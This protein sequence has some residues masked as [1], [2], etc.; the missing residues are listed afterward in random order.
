MVSTAIGCRRIIL[1]GSPPLLETVL[2]EENA[3]EQ[4]KKENGKSSR[5]IML[6]LNA[7]GLFSC[8]TSKPEN[9]LSCYF[10]RRH[11]LGQVHNQWS[12][13]MFGRGSTGDSR[14]AEQCMYVCQFLGK[15]PKLLP[16]PDE[17]FS[18]FI[19]DDSD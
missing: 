17:L 10:W 1:G 16:E 5:N 8:K 12:W 14:V 3:V 6:R 18:N 2:G 19:L 13:S 9:I 15:L 11:R 7:M 4:G